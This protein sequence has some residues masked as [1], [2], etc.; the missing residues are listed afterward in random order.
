MDRLDEYIRG[1]QSGEVPASDAVA[2]AV[3]RR[4]RWLRG[5]RHHWAPGKFEAKMRLIESALLID[6]GQPFRLFGWQVFCLAEIFGW[7]DQDGFRIRRTAHILTAKGSGKTPFT[8][9]C[10]LAAAFFDD[11]PEPAAECFALAKRSEQSKVMFRC[12]AEFVQSSPYLEKRI[13]IYGGVHPTELIGKGKQSGSYI[14]R[15]SADARKGHHGPRVHAMLVDE[16]HEFDDDATRGAL[17]AGF[18]NRRQPIELIS[19]NAGHDAASPFGLEYAR[20]HDYLAR[21][22]NDAYFFFCAENEK[23][24]FERGGDFPPEAAW[25]KSNPSLPSHPTYAYIR[26]QCAEARGNPSMVAA[27]QR[28]NFSAWVEGTQEWLGMDA[29][30]KCEVEALS[31]DRWEQPC[32]MGLDLSLSRD[33]SS[34]AVVWDFGD[35]MEAELWNWLPAAGLERRIMIDK[36]PYRDW[37]S[38]G[39]ITLCAGEFISLADV[40]V[41]V[42]DV[43]LRAGAHCRGVAFDAWKISHLKRELTLLGVRHEVFHPESAPDSA[44]GALFLL[45]HPQG[46]GRPSRY[47]GVHM[48]SSISA[49][50]RAIVDGDLRMRKMPLLYSAFGSVVI[51]Q[52]PQENRRFEKVKAARRI[53]PVVALA[54]AVGFAAV[55]RVQVGDNLTFDDL[56]A[57]FLG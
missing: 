30:R 35:R 18:K 54:M 2:K 1:V 50:E 36:M 15:T 11:P 32:F 4:Q 40:A 51:S 37:V 5:G 52:D 46:S 6:G 39:D 41:R 25:P 49:L 47:K 27:V 20:A 16:Y 19:S 53:D 29:I 33:L 23:A 57:G 43:W 8:S 21:D 31:D 28:L 38:R 45:S 14:R 48:E 7:V 42:Q 10:L 17:R 56:M 22:A 9:A 3:E 55:N 44:P 12:L 24:D 13:H 34:L 26:Q